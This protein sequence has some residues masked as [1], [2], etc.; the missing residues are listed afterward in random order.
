[1]AGKTQDP[2]GELSAVPVS[3]G[4][5]LSALCS[6]VQ[7]MFTE[8]LPGPSAFLGISAHILLFLWSHIPGGEAK[9]TSKYMGKMISSRGVRNREERRVWDGD[10]L[11]L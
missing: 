7:Q 4:S 9:P 11:L 1:M 6:S 10:C 3:S 2:K 8:P 5:P